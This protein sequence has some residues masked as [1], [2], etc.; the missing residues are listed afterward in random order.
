MPRVVLDADQRKAADAAGGSDLKCLFA[1]QEVSRDNQLLFFHHGVVTVEKFASLAKDRDDLVQLLKDHWALD[2]DNSLNE[3][4]QVAAIVCAY[5]HA[6]S[7]SDKA[8]EYEAE[9]DI[10][11]RA[12][13]LVPSEWMIMKQAL[14]TRYGPM[15]DKMV[16]SKE[17][18]E[19]KLSEVESGEYRAEQ[20]TEIVSK[21]EVDPD[22]MVPVWDNRG[23]FTMRKGSSKVAEPANAEELRKRLTIMRNAYVLIALRHTNRPE[24]QGNY[25]RVFEEYKTYLLGEYV[26]GLVAKDPDGNTIASP[27]WSLVLTY[28]AAIR[29]Q[30]VKE[31]NQDRAPFPVALKS[32]WQNAIVKERNFTTPLAL[33]AKRPP[34]PSPSVDYGAYASRA[35]KQQKGAGN[36]GKAGGRGKG[37]GKSIQGGHCA[38]HTP[39][40]KMICYR[41]NSGEKCKQKKC[42]FLH[43]CGICFS[44]NH[45]IP[46][47]TSKTRQDPPRDTAGAGAA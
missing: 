47:C 1:K 19:K 17:F 39:E 7:R 46:Q 33:Y 44:P 11:D 18:L 21:E 26:Y 29:K 37:V 8:A 3:R 13:P 27:P 16:P 28:E 2:Q 25:D 12:K 14:D 9:F 30:A 22:T 45:A 34:P 32:A 15:E 5:K 24:L 23:K 6:S 31:V 43:V 20:L 40:G 36:K 42:K 4:V 41:F 10:Q 38:S 35:S